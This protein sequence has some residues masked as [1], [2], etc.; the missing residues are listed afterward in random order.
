MLCSFSGKFHKTLIISILTVF[1]FVSELFSQSDF[2]ENLNY[3]TI[4]SEDDWAI[5]FHSG[6]ATNPIIVRESTLTNQV[7]NLIR[8][9][10]KKDVETEKPSRRINPIVLLLA[11]LFLIC[12]SYSAN[13]GFVEGQISQ[14]F[15]IISYIHS[16]DGRKRLSLS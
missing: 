5:I 4:S 15:S 2:L 1:L 8:L 16:K 3:S 11:V 12:S 9:G 6:S 7:N 14:R 10:R 13:F